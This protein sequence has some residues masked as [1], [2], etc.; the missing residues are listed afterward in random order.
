[1]DHQ[2]WNRLHRPG[3]RVRVTKAD[4]SVMRARTAAPALR[5]GQH[6]FVELKGF[7]GLWLL[8]WCRALPRPGPEY[9][10][11]YLKRHPERYPGEFPAMLARA[12]F[13]VATAESRGH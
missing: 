7:R 12:G 1:M 4:G 8:S 13:R 3:V 2:E 10:A 9:F 6:E 11:E 5:V